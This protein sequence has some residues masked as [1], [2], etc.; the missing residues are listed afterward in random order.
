MMTTRTR[1]DVIP[2]CWSMPDPEKV[3][4]RASYGV[5]FR[6]IGPKI[7]DCPQAARAVPSERG[8]GPLG[9]C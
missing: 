3:P 4:Y 2:G 7:S 8:I 1:S 9:L 5:F 6:P